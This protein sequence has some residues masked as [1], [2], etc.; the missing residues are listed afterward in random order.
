MLQIRP[1]LLVFAVSGIGLMLGLWV[2]L[3]HAYRLTGEILSL[4][5]PDPYPEPA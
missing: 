5:T 1:F 2:V 3:W 4:A